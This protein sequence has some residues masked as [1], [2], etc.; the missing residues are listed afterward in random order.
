[1]GLALFL[2]VLGARGNERFLI[3]FKEKG[4]RLGI[5]LGIALAKKLRSPKAQGLTGYKQSE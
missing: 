1:M 5:R 4:S 2:G 3:A